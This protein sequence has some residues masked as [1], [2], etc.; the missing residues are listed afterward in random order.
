MSDFHGGHRAR[1][2]E[3][4]AEEGLSGFAPHEAL[5]L[6][7]FYAIPQRNVNPLAHALIDRFGTLERVLAAPREE[8]CKVE[9]VGEYAASLLKL[10]HAVSLRLNAERAAETEVLATSEDALEYCAGLLRGNHKERFF[11]ICLDAQLHVIK[12]ECIAEGSVDEVPAYP[13]LAVEAALRHNARQ[14]I[15]CH[16]HPGGSALPSDADL[17]A[18]RRLCDALRT[19]QIGV[20]DHII[21]TDT[22]AQSLAALRLMPASE[23]ENP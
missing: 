9:G 6:M 5:E 19:V 13:R 2:R 12:A 17:D 18:T 20:P 23:G 3:R 10:F 21:V 11:V 8:L 16:N 7:L 4:F 1:M 15:L 22:Q 14:V